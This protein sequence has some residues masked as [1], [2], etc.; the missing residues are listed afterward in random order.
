MADAVVFAP[1][2]DH[3]TATGSCATFLIS[4]KPFKTSNWDEPDTWLTA[5]TPCLPAV[6][7]PSTSS[8]VYGDALGCKASPC[9]L[10]KYF[11]L[12]WVTL[13]ITG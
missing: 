4:F 8:A 1:V 3:N 12:N 13:F 9:S 2:C 7:L 11:M 10:I 5:T 6:Q